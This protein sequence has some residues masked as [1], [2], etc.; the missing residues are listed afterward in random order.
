MSSATGLAGRLERGESLLGALIR[1]PADPVLDMVGAAGLDLV[2]IDPGPGRIDQVRL[3]SDLLRLRVPGAVLVRDAADLAAAADAGPAALVRVVADRSEI[4][5]A[6]TSVTDRA[7]SWYGDGRSE[8]PMLAA[9]SIGDAGVLHLAGACVPYSVVTS[10]DQARTARAGGAR[11]VVYDM[12]SMLATL[13]RSLPLGDASPGQG[14]GR[15]PLVLLSG[16]L[17]DASL[18]DGVASRL[19]D[20]ARPIPSRIDL[21]DSIVE[22][23]ASVL[24]EA[25]PSFSLVGHSLGGIV[26]L[27]VVRQAPDR[28][29][30]FALLNASARGPSPAQHEAWAALAER[31]SGGQWPDVAA[32]LARSNLP[33]ARR[34]ENDL[35]E[36]SER[37]AA[38]VGPDGLLRQLRAQ[39]G[40]P[41][42][43]DSLHR[44]DVP[45]L[46]VSG[47]L[48]EVCPP[49]LQQELVDGCPDATLVEVPTGHMSPLEDPDAVAEAVLTWLRAQ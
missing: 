9:I 17:G 42:S 33:A 5:Q 11:V 7:A 20:V 47:A 22:M 4:D 48:D 2:L 26:A 19:A 31:V 38:A 21:D 1:T 23:A 30:R 44:I 41:D 49:A 45:V 6:L 40:R 25:P 10:P 14:G 35:V 46:V 29:R 27:E 16:M 37:M 34:S 13:V 8:P 36:T 24:A 3:R 39:A 28:V 12:P 18:W 32:E 15:E 43:R